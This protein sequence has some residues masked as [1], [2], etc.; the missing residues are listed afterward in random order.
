MVEADPAEGDLRRILN[1]GHTLGHAIEGALRYETLRHGEAVA[2]GLLFASRLA[3]R[4]GK[5][6]ELEGRL[7]TLLRRFELPALPPLETSELVAFMGRDKKALEGGL[8]WVLPEQLGRGEMVSG[9][10]REEIEGELGLF[11]RDPWAGP[12]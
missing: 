12:E 11:L 6:R 3:V 9:I 5:A 4:R 2:Y 1:F 7:R 10:G 8:V